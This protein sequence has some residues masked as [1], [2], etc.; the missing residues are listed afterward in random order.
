V[1]LDFFRVRKHAAD[2]GSGSGGGSAYWLEAEAAEHRHE[3]PLQV[4]QA[5][6]A[7]Q[8]RARRIRVHSLNNVPSPVRT[9]IVPEVPSS[10]RGDFGR[11]W[12]VLLNFSAGALHKCILFPG[13][14]L[15]TEHQ[16]KGALVLLASSKDGTELE[17]QRSI[18]V[19]FDNVAS[20]IR[21]PLPHG[22][23]GCH[24]R[25]HPALHRPNGGAWQV[26]PATSSTHI[27]NPLLRVEWG[28]L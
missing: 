28:I 15:G 17:E 20:N 13:S 14:W 16:L 3:L 27:L 8:A 22:D 19:L 26:L 1:K 25:I 5:R 23:E 12:A 7:S 10:V 21:Q 2:S 24:V 11:F 4:V 18:C 9:L 6:D